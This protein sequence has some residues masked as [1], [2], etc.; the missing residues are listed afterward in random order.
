MLAV[1]ATSLPPPPAD[2][3]SNASL[4]LDFDGTIVEIAE[5]PDAVIVSDRLRSLI[6]RLLEGLG[7]RVTIVSGRN[8]AEVKRLIEL[9]KLAVAGSHGLELPVL[10]NGAGPVA[11]PAALDDAL[12]EMQRFAADRPGLLV[13]DKPLGAALHF[14]LRP[15]ADLECRDFAQALAARSALYL[16]T[17]KMMY[18]L[19][20]GDCDK[21]S[22]LVHLMADPKLNGTRPV[23]I[24]DDD[25]DEPAF[26]AAAELGGSGI[27]IGQPRP[28]AARYGLPDVPA[29]LAWLEAA[30]PQ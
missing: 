19:R 26:V 12:R 20:V 10:Q 5:T 21:G 30:C 7:G 29:V 17:G 14:R 9:E 16:Q 18:E 15:E 1:S 8:A 24:G 28:T 3:L 4:F 2:L 11:R 6:D 22:A 25:T 13:E 23:F 27:L